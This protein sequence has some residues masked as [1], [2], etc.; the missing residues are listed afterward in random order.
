MRPFKTISQF[1]RKL[2]EHN[3][4]QLFPIR[5]SLRGYD[6]GKAKGDLRAGLN[7]ALLAFPQGM[8]YAAIAGLPIQYGIFA[9]AIAAMLGPLFSG[10]RFIILGPT[11]AT[12]VLVFASFLSLGIFAPGEKVAMISLIVLLSG[13]FLVLGAFLKV[14]NLIQYIS[15]S[16]VTG[17]I[18]A[19]AIYIIVNQLRKAL[20]FDFTGLQAL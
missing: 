13:I 16:V 10:S 1:S 12:S 19:A 5:D 11:N 7:V 9:S 20:G 4:L 18:T 3:H 15:R 2:R 6:A 14:A 17:Y 8:A